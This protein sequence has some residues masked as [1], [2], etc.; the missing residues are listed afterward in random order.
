MLFASSC[1]LPARPTTGLAGAN[2]WARF[3]ACTP[4]S[5]LNQLPL[6]SHSWGR[7]PNLAIPGHA[8]SSGSDSSDPPPC[9][10]TKYHGPASCSLD[11]ICL[12]LLLLDTGKMSSQPRCTTPYSRSRSPLPGVGTCLL[13]VYKHP[14]SRM[15]CLPSSPHPASS[16]PASWVLPTTKPFAKVFSRPSLRARPRA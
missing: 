13:V 11:G 8:Q 2:R 10:S 5:V 16:S 12:K 7:L 15:V 4:P 3:Y 6:R 9:P 1:V 14:A